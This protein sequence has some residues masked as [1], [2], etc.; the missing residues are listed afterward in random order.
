MEITSGIHFPIGAEMTEEVKRILN[1]LSLEEKIAL[2]SGKDFWH[3]EAMN[4]EELPEVM[5]CDGP[6]GLRKQEEK[7]DHLGINESIKTV[8][9]PSASALAASFDLNVL[10]ELGDAL[11]QECQAENIG[12]L[13]GPGLNMKRSPLC[14]RN[15]E[16]FSEDPYLAG[17]LACA[18][19]KG[20]QKRGVAACVKHFAANNQ[21]TQRMNSSSN[22]DERTLREIYLPAFEM[23]VKEGKTRSIMCAYN[24]INGIFCSENKKLLNDILREEWGFEGFVVTDWGAKKGAAAGVKAGLNLVMPGGHGTHE[25]MLKESLKNHELTEEQLNT[26]VADILQFILDAYR[27]KLPNA[28]I[29]REKCSEL[30]GELAAQCAVL[31]KNE[32]ILPLKKD[33]KIA[34]IG[35]FA[36]HPRYQGSGSSH[37]N[38]SKT[39]CAIETLKEK[40]AC[41][42]FAKGFDADTVNPDKEL[43]QE[44]VKI[45]EASEAAV[46]FAG[47]PD[48]FESEGFD[49]E[50]LD[51]PENQNALIEAICKVQ[52]NVIVVLHGGSPMLLPW[53]D[54][55]KGILCMYLGGQEVGRAAVELLYG[56]KN[57]SGKLAE[58][59]PLRLEDTPSYLNFPGVDGIV[60]YREDIF[61]GYRYYDK[62]KMK[63]QYPFGHGLSY[64][65]F[66]YSDL[67]TDK[68]TITDK[69]TLHVSCKIKNTGTCAGKE[70]VQLYVKDVESSVERPVRELKGFAK[71]YLNPG[72]EKEVEFTLDKRSFSYYETLISDWFVESG[73]FVIEIGASSRD[74][75]LSQSIQVEGTGE[76]PYHYTE[77]S[78]LCSLQRTNKGQKMLKRILSAMTSNT[79]QDFTQMESLGDGADKM[80]W[81]ILMEMPLGT[82]AGLGIMSDSELEILLNNLNSSDCSSGE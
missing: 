46:I 64:T 68:I 19:I 67:K 6:H 52:K 17:K 35:D 31:L 34:V 53:E 28:E 2:C 24:A 8:C 77:N 40:E 79:Q 48:A 69:E 21:E 73:E 44:A 39:I 1:K 36:K 15:F 23:A 22:V 62:K 51:L 76:L 38:A 29:D 55:V 70:I 30:S 10:S 60:N 75:R 45:A 11:G 20:L 57:P 56:E 82:I 27:N 59:W 66:S 14:G 7:S 42:L 71:I 74:I 41:F 54:Q 25:Q 33:T 78:L 26:A 3:T 49:R 13:L 47:L 58:T 16:Y 81:K 65:S 4:C 43:I 37:I 12:M 9:Y 80:K 72:E 5:M 32:D 63:V 18:Y 50:H 61:I